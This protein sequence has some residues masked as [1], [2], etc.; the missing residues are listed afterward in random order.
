MIMLYPR[1]YRLSRVE[2][3]WR[4]WRDLYPAPM[5]GFD[6]IPVAPL[7]WWQRF[8]Y[9]RRGFVNLNLGFGALTV[10]WRRQP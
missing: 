5:T 4:T 2:V 9:V 3:A 7:R 8:V 1:P 10:S 6:L